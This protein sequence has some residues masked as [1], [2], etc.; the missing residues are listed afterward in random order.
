MP[1]ARRKTLAS[2]DKTGD[3]A[4]QLACLSAILAAAVDRCDDPRELAQLSRQYREA[5][6]ELA[7]VRAGEPGDADIVMEI[8]DRRGR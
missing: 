4:E 5:T 6:R 7:E 8:R 1:V 2:A 3:R